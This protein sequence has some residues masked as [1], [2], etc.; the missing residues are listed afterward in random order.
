MPTE[1]KRRLRLFMQVSKAIHSGTGTREILDIIVAQV[2]ALL[3]AMGAIFWIVDTA[4]GVIRSKVA[5][6]FTYRSLMAVDYAL[7]ADIFALPRCGP[8]HIDDA[9]SDPRLPNLERLGKKRVATI[10]AQPVPIVDEVMGVLALY[11]NRHRRLSTDDCDLVAGLADQGAI[12]LQ[13]ALRF[14]DAQLE[15]FR[16]T[17]AGLVLALEAKDPVT[18]GHSRR[19]ARFARET[20]RALALEETECDSIFQAALLHDIGKIGLTDH[21][22]G[23]Q[24]KLTAGEMHRLRQHPAVGVRILQPL[25]MF[26]DLLPLVRHHHERFDGTGYPDGLRGGEIPLGAR[27]LAVCDVFETMLSGRA[28]IEARSLAQAL[29][30]LGQGS[31]SQ[32]D[33]AVVCALRATIERHPEILSD[34]EI[35]DDFIVALLTEGPPSSAPRASEAVLAHRFPTAF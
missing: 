20:A 14:D 9:R 8:I 26:N 27:V 1:L 30:Q 12:A 5:W 23:R 7:L 11:F 6:G 17:V 16:Q 19:V 2:A 33:P 22:L 31:G 18:H 4:A 34:W 28:H 15:I 3:D 24:G 25:R 29:A 10:H 35:D 32:F 13:K 21:I